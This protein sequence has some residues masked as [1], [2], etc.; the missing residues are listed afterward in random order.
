MCGIAGIFHLDGRPVSPEILQA[1]TRQLKHRGPDSEG[2]HI[3]SMIGLGHRRLSILDLS[4]AGHQPMTSKDG[5]YTISYNGELYNFKELRTDLEKR[6]EQFI[7]TSDTE[8]FLSAFAAYGPSA[9]EK[10]DGMFAAAL[11]DKN[12][13]T[14]T[15]ARDRYGVKPLYIT[16][17][18]QTVLFGSEIKA[19]FPYPHFEVGIDLESL[20]EYLTFQNFVT[21]RTLFKGAH[22]LR[23]GSFVQI[24]LGDTS[25]QAPK[26]YWDFIFYNTE[27]PKTESEYLEELDALFSQAVHRQLVS[28][29]EIGSYL[30]GGVDSGSIAMLSSRKLPHLKTFTCGFDLHSASGLE[31]AFDEREGAEWL[32][33]LMKSEQYEIVL[34]SGDMERCMA[35]LT[36]HLEEPRVGQSYPSYYAALLASKFVKVVLSGA[37]GDELFAG[38]P[39]RYY[40]AVVNQDFADYT[41]KYFNF[42]Q[43]LLP[44][45]LLQQITAPIAGAVKHINPLDIFRSVFPSPTLELHTPEDYINYSLYFE[46]KTFLHGLL[47]M[48]DKLSMA[49]GLETRVPF[50]D[51]AL[52][53]FARRLPV[54]Y[55]LKNLSEVVRMNENE[56]GGKNVHYF[57]KTGDGKLLLRKVMSRYVPEEIASKDKQGFSAPDASWFKGDSIEYVKKKLLG[58]KSFISEYLDNKIVHSLV[59]DHVDGK[60][61]RRLLIWGLLYLENWH[62]QFIA[63]PRHELVGAAV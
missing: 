26:Q 63:R 29:V 42:W 1:M 46:A 14:L 31:L 17:C 57:Q 23:P 4:P 20:Y 25:L 36:W 15:L 8:V 24:K 47:V 9:F 52:V 48:E 59:H 55:K 49:H 62:E 13:F 35:E 33:Y 18:G 45:S 12:T 10:F 54:K 21:E 41:N 37:G 22:L 44:G 51:N 27:Q 16:Q 43:R 11:W 40:R 56:P 3:E 32:S 50:L 6:G 39:W 28:D 60:E 19:F 2:F 5:R 61:N 7:S 53:D 58:P 38:Y 34:K 30:S